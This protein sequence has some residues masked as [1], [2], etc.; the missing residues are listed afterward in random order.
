MPFHS[1]CGQV[2]CLPAS[3][4]LEYDPRDLLNNMVKDRTM[5]GAADWIDWT[6]W[7]GRE[8]S[9]M[10]EFD[11]ESSVSRVEFVFA[12]STKAVMKYLLNI[13]HISLGVSAVDLALSVSKETSSGMLCVLEFILRTDHRRP[14]LDLKSMFTVSK[15]FSLLFLSIRLIW[16]FKLRNLSLSLTDGWDLSFYVQTPFSWSGRELHLTAKEQG[17]DLFYVL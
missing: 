17:K 8:M 3:T 11:V 2:L 10:T 5:M 13:P 1:F 14:E 12:F 6:S 7:T 15:N 16:A 9:K 4:H